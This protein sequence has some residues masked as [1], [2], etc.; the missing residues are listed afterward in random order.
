MDDKHA[1]LQ[2]Q[3]NRYPR[4]AAGRLSHPRIALRPAERAGRTAI[5]RLAQS[6]GV[7][8]DPVYTGKAIAGLDR[9]GRAQ[10]VGTQ[11]ADHL[12][13]PRRSA[14]LVC[15]GIGQG[16]SVVNGQRKLQLR[17]N[18]NCVK[19]LMPEV[20]VIQLRVVAAVLHQPI[21]IALFDD[22]SLLA[23]R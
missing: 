9:S 12:S 4:V 8:L 15:E 18:L 11:R 23:A 3:L 1:A 21:V 22:L 17:L 14:G 2:A 5:R 10:A 19:A 16:G 6:E 20:G 13:A 7:I